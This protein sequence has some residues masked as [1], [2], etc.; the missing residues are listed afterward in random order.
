MKRTHVLVAALATGLMF[1]AVPASATARQADEKA[2]FSLTRLSGPKVG[3]LT[4]GYAVVAVDDLRDAATVEK[5]TKVV[6]VRLPFR[7]S[8]KVKPGTCAIMAVAGGRKGTR[9]RLNVTV[10]G[11]V[12]SSKQGKAPNN[13]YC[14]V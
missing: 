1:T 10:D 11:A 4:V 3:K 2:V 12:E 9:L 13:F 6:N 14:N 8:L 7:K 5:A